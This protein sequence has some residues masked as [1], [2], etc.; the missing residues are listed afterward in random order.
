M[1]GGGVSSDR[2][3]QYNRRRKTRRLYQGVNSH[4]LRPRVKEDQ[5][6]PGDFS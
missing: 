1:K 3:G 6:E 4:S 2:T 5:P